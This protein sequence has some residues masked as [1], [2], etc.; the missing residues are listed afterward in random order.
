MS[1][2]IGV[3]MNADGYSCIPFQSI[4]CVKSNISLMGRLVPN[5]CHIDVRLKPGNN[6]TL[7]YLSLIALSWLNPKS[8][9]ILLSDPSIPLSKWITGNDLIVS[10]FPSSAL[11]YAASCNKKV[12]LLRN[13]C[14]FF[15]S[16]IVQND[17]LSPLVTL[18]EIVDLILNCKDTPCI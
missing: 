1:Y 9:Q 11:H 12:F 15:P 14:N 8:C 16:Y 5:Y 18:P 10:Y 3:I 6:S 7:D 4:P 13:K 17:S 2:K